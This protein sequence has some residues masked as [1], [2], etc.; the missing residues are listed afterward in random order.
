MTSQYLYAHMSNMASGTEETKDTR[1]Q[2]HFL[3]AYFV[4]CF[5][6]FRALEGVTDRIKIL[7]F[8]L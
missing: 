4:S 2:H 7:M 6:L 3:S 8:N 5:I 1:D